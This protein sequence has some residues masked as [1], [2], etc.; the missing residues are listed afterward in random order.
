MCAEHDLG[1]PFS[2]EL[3]EVPKMKFLYEVDDDDDYHHVNY[4][5]KAL[6]SEGVAQITMPH[7]LHAA[8]RRRDSFDFWF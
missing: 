2:D 6:A 1:P 3:S 4:V 5:L 8:H 7:K